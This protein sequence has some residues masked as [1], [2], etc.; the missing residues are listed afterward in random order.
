MVIM[1]TYATAPLAV[2]KECY[3]CSQLYSTHRDAR[4]KVLDNNIHTY[5]RIAYQR[6]DR[7]TE[8]KQFHL[9]MLL[10]VGRHLF[11]LS[12]ACVC[13]LRVGKYSK[14]ERKQ[15]TYGMQQSKGN[16]P[17]TYDCFFVPFAMLYHGA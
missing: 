3:G 17:H 9:D 8:G 13:K 12:L 1:Y 16:I 11:F 2:L 5:V 10:H 4:G 14:G 7:L 6:L 15:K